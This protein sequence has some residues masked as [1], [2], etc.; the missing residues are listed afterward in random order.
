MDEGAWRAVQI[1]FI[2]GLLTLVVMVIV[3]T[4]QKRYRRP[5]G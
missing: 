3:G 5:P 1:G 2:G 4:I